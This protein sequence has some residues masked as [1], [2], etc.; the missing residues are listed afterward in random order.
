MSSSLALRKNASVQ[1]RCKGEKVNV[2]Y[3]SEKGPLF[4]KERALNEI[5]N[6]TAE[7]AVFTVGTSKHYRGQSISE[8]EQQWV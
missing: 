1:N 5:K 3:V 2:L 8:I 4:G 7:T 6:T